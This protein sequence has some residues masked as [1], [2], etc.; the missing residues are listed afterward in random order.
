MVKPLE[1][2][3][4]RFGRLTVIEKNGRKNGSIL[5]KCKCDCGNTAIISGTSLKNGNTKSCGC[6]HREMLAK[7]NK[8]NAKYG[9]VQNERLYGVWHSMKQRCYDSNRKDYPRYGA[10]GIRVCDDWFENYS[11]FKEWAL[12]NGYK[13][14]LQIDRINNDGNYTP[15]NCRWV[16]PRENSL[17][18]SNKTIINCA[19]KSMNLSKW[20]ELLGVTHQAIHYH[21]LAGDVDTYIKRIANERRIELWK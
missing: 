19:G 3:G 17:N 15:K 11:A 6:L 13:R 21:V 7:R 12:K 1:L 20:A 5:W 4:K 10:R 16:P 8:K 18:K 9:G 2:S 14:G